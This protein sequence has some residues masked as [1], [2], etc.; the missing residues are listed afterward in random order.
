MWNIFFCISRVDDNCGLYTIFSS[1]MEHYY[2]SYMPKVSVY[3]LNHHL[4]PAWWNIA[5]LQQMELLSRL[6]GGMGGSSGSAGAAAVAAAAA[7]GLAGYP[8]LHPE[9][10]MNLEIIQAQHGQY[11]RLLCSRVSVLCVGC[12]IYATAWSVLQ[13]VV[14]Q[15][16][17][18]LGLAYG[19][20]ATAQLSAPLFFS[21]IYLPSAPWVR[22]NLTVVEVKLKKN[23]SNSLKLPY[24]I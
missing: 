8:G 3:I 5:G 21:L 23:I 1:I 2:V 17:I 4:F 10:L 11:H 22:K 18:V 15:S 20:Y 24:Y 6:Q 16:C 12:I 9:H 14:Q 13:V 7:G 19:I